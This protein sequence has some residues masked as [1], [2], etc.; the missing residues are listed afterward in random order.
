MTL[1]SKIIST[2]SCQHC[3]AE[4]KLAPSGRRKRYCSDACRQAAFR[5][6]TTANRAPSYPSKGYENCA[7]EPIETQD[8]FPSRN[9]ELEL[10]R[11]SA[12]SSKELTFQKLNSITWKLTDGVQIN[13][14]SGRASRALGYVV[15]VAPGKWMARV[16]NL[17]SELL[18]FGAAKQEAVRLYR[19]RDKGTMD[20]I[21]QLNLR[22]AAEINRTAL[23]SEKRKAP[24]DLIGGKRQGHIDP[25]IRAT[26]LEAEIGFLTCA[27]PETI[28]GDD[29]PLKYDSDGYPELPVGLDRRR[30]RLKQAA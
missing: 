16:R 5:N 9:E 14:G 24:V 15:E 30:P 29:Y 22:A 13:T 17:G 19:C 18:S 20:W 4:L 23:A 6:E 21:G 11:S 10:S 27:R 2:S 26:V 1:H 12:H 8:D 7:L 28:K 25:K 3:G